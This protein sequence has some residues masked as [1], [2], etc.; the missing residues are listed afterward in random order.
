MP[1]LQEFCMVGW[2]GR[3]PRLLRHMNR[4]LSL[5][6]ALAVAVCLTAVACTGHGR[7]AIIKPAPPLPA[8][9]LVCG[10]QAEVTTERE[11]LRDFAGRF[12]VPARLLAGSFA[13][14]AEAA[15]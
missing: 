2:P 12:R 6:A 3:L 13:P 11:K 5:P 7:T 1:S 9:V 8:S 4:R 15:R 10:N 14:T